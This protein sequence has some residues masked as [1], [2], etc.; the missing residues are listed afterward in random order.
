MR[1]F[2]SLLSYRTS[3]KH[4]TLPSGQASSMTWL[5]I[6]YDTVFGG[7]RAYA[8]FHLLLVSIEAHASVGI[9]EWW[10]YHNSNVLSACLLAGALPVL[11]CLRGAASTCRSLGLSVRTY[12]IAT[13]TATPVSSAGNMQLVHAHAWCRAVSR[14]SPRTRTGVISSGIWRRLVVLHR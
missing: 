11:R 8:A 1:S 14:P 5:A 10:I 13:R 3:T 6:L 4:A 12:A 2:Y 7:N 9:C